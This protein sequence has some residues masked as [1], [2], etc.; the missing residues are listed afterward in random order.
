MRWKTVWRITSFSLCILV[1][2][3]GLALAACDRPN[4]GPSDHAP[5]SIPAEPPGVPPTPKPMTGASP[6]ERS[7]PPQPTGLVASTPP[8][9]GRPTEEPTATTPLPTESAAPGPLKPM[10]ISRAFPLLSFTRLTNLAQP[11]DGS[12]L[13]FV[14]EQEGTIAAF[15]NDPQAAEAFVF[16]DIRGRVST[17]GNEEGLL[18]LA[19]DPGY[20]DNGRFYVYYSAAR[21]R[22]S[23]LSRFIASREHPAIADPGSEV[24]IMEVPQPYSNHNGGQLAFGPDG[25]LYL[26]LGDG[27][28]T[29]DPQS[30]G[31]N[32]GT[33][34]GSVIRIDVSLETDQP[35]YRIPEDN[36]FTGIE[37]AGGEIWAYGLRNPWRFS[38]DRET[39]ALWLGDV[40]QHLWEEVNQIE[41]G[42]N[43]GWNTMEG[44]HCFKP[45]S[46]CDATGL[47]LPL[48]E[49]SSKEGCSVIGGY[50]Y[51]GPRLPSLTG[52]YVYADYCS[53]SIWALR[54][55]HG[56][57]SDQRL[58]ASLDK[59]IT[60]FGEDQEGNL[61]ILSRN[62]GIY[63]LTELEAP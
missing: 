20:V 45:R 58:V 50:V 43:Y 23:V 44:A 2:A 22:R 38:F 49:Y 11:P 36:P 18:G 1:A 26:G 40:G 28:S 51:R 7:S 25:Y 30:N 56:S 17:D 10:G 24:V 31:Q 42:R 12:N 33:L 57:V 29:G 48:L 63:E 46:G 61:Y 8:G 59:L 9:E 62:S 37:G 13:L 52:A 39:G 55:E 35:G 15:P 27:G 3:F 21:P 53:G 5:L 32:L 60:S 16:L 6:V 47:E 19:F 4:A 14:A 54:E 41:M 34:L